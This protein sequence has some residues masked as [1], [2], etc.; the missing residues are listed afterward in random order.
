MNV[1]YQK[2]TASGMKLTQGVALTPY[3]AAQQ[4]SMGWVM[5]HVPSGYCVFPSPFESKELA[6]GFAQM[7]ALAYQDR[8]SDPSGSFIHLHD[9]ET[10]QKL[11]LVIETVA[12]EKPLIVHSHYLENLIGA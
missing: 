10:Q 9:T 1:T 6:T 12:T 2:R 4:E 7:M 8:L 3:F 5:T 11:R